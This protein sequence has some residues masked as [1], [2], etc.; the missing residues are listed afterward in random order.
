MIK[1]PLHFNNSEWEE[2]GDPHAID[3]VR[4]KIIQWVQVFFKEELHE[5]TFVHVRQGNLEHQWN[6]WE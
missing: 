1:N 6:H 4:L 5:W 3:I 2:I